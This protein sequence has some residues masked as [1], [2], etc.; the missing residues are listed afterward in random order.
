MSDKLTAEQLAKIKPI[1]Y[2]DDE[3][4][5]EGYAKLSP[6]QL[7][8]INR[9]NSGNFVEGLVDDAITPDKDKPKVAP[10]PEE[11]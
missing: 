11:D 1:P 5:D 2:N 7:Q 9:Q 6:E 4:E 10:L 8:R 3:Q